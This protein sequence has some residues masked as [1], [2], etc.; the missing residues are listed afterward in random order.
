MKS[1]F[2]GEIRN[3]WVTGSLMY[4]PRTWIALVSRRP[5]HVSFSTSPLSKAGSAVASNESRFH[6]PSKPMRARRHSKSGGR[7]LLPSASS[8]P[9][10]W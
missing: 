8:A 5:T 2:A 1:V 4:P 3:S 7:E 10:S 6:S 9:Q